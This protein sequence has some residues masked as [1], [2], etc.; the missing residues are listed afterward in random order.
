MYFRNDSLLLSSCRDTQK[1]VQ[2]E[3]RT[4]ALTFE[5]SNEKFIYSKIISNLMVQHLRC[6]VTAI[7]LACELMI[8]ILITMINT[9]NIIIS[10][11][12]TYNINTA[13]K[14]AWTGRLGPRRLA[15]PLDSY[16]LYNFFYI[17]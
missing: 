3:E 10:N 6:T 14:G 9:I 15:K 4:V 11:G 12:Y 17:S 16:Y 1:R 13:Q 2:L 7:S 5:D 8:I